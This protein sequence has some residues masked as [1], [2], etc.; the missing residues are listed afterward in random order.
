[1]L[2]YGTPLPDLEKA[3]VS[4]LLQQQQQRR[5]ASVADRFSITQAQSFLNKFSDELSDTN[6]TNSDEFSSD[7]DEFSGDDDNNITN[8]DNVLKGDWKRNS[9]PIV[10]QNLKKPLPIFLPNL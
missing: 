1:M 7:D 5:P 3:R 9:S 4:V 8:N 2:T 6:T 10:L